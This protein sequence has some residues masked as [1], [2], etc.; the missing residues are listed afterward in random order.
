MAD[1]S[2]TGAM[3]KAA[4]NLRTLVSN[5][6]TFRTATAAGDA[7]AALAFIHLAA[8][9]PESSFTRP[10]AVICRQVDESPVV[11]SG[12]WLGNGVLEL[13][14][15]KGISEAYRADDEA[16]NAELEFLNFVDG[17]IA[18][19]QALSGGAGEYLVTRTWRIDDGPALIGDDGVYMIK[20]AVEWGLV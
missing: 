3:G 18:D 10:F 1:V 17:V 2:P 11:G 6:S 14:L 8:Y 13:W 5:S 12:G 19:C 20:I 7:A 15:E 16:D 4:A 9:E